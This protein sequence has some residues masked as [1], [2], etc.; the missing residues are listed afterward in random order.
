M[1]KAQFVAG[2][3]SVGDQLAQEDFLVGVQRVGDQVQQLRDFGLK[4]MG[5]FAHV[6]KK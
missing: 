4:G 2:V 5:L 1:L 3:R 6:D